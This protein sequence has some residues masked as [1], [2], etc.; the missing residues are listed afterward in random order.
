VSVSVASF[1]SAFHEPR[2]LHSRV[3][4]VIFIIEVVKHV[5]HATEARA[6]SLDCKDVR[7]RSL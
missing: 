6:A 2:S 4:N 3:D 7:E 5:S 1:S